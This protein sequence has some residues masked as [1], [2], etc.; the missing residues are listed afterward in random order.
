MAKYLLIESRDSF[1]C[2][3]VARDL[4]IAVNL[5]QADN[6][7][8]LYLVQNGVLSARR[9]ALPGGLTDVLKAGVHVWCDEFS[10]KERGI[11]S[12]GLILGIRPAPLDLVVDRLADGSKTIW[13]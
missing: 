6:D 7:V 13:L 8:M 1:E 3:E 9:G 11:A 5:K 12:T 10:L 2:A 4:E